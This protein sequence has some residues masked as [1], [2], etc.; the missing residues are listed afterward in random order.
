VKTSKIN[1]NGEE[2]ITSLVNEG[3]FFGYAALLEELPYSD[4]AVALEE[5][6][7]CIIPKKIFSRCFTTAAKSPPRSFACLIYGWHY[8]KKGENVCYRIKIWLGI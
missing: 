2:F 8:L 7:I 4:K 3:E 5:S 1:E 6:E